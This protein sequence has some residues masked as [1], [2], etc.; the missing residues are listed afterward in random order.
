MP[1]TPQASDYSLES[2]PMDLSLPSWHPLRSPIFLAT[3]FVPILVHLNSKYD[4]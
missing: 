1:R 2:V 4:D 3:A